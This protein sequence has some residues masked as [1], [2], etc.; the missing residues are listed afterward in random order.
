MSFA[1]SADVITVAGLELALL[2][3][4][5]CALDRD[6]KLPLSRYLQWLRALCHP[7]SM[8]VQ[9]AATA[10]EPPTARGEA[11]AHLEAM[12]TVK[13]AELTMGLVTGGYATVVGASYAILD[14]ASG[15][16]GWQ[17]TLMALN[18]LM[19]GYLFF[20]SGWWRNRVLLPLHQ[21]VGRD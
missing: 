19:L 20:F 1:V 15:L 11:E 6:G 9:P 17:A 8:P 18:T 3:I 5:G 14:S 13:R 4:V 7:R 12:P 21:R 16:Q 2:G 10:D